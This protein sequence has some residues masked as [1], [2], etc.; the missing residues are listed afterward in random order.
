MKQKT[1]RQNKYKSDLEKLYVKYPEAKQVKDRYKVMR[2]ILGREWLSLSKIEQNV[3]EDILKDA[4]YV[5]RLIRRMT[6]GVDE[7]NKTILSQDFQLET[8]PNM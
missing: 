2:T 7:E 6:E 5:D 3:L 4:I 1:L 8:L